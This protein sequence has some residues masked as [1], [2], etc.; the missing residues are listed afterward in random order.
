[1]DK[2]Q[3]IQALAAL[4]QETRMAVFRLLASADA[5]GVPA[6]EIADALNVQ[7]NTLSTHL[8]IL[9]SSGL[10]TQQKEGRVIRYEADKNA[11]SEV[12]LFLTH[13]ASA[14]DMHH[15]QTLK[16]TANS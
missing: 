5:E 3:A 8:S 1:M 2:D 4:A 6:G 14:N 15:M 16:K 9:V 12:I 7:P 10:I 13:H 11:L